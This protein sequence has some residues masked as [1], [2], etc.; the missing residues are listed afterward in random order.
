VGDSS[1]PNDIRTLR[2]RFS[3]LEILVTGFRDFVMDDKLTK[4][5]SKLQ[6]ASDR[7]LSASFPK[8]AFYVEPADTTGLI[9][10]VHLFPSWIQEAVA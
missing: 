5:S 3:V 1:F 2:P 7:T 6:L 4:V 10:T 9:A 8:V